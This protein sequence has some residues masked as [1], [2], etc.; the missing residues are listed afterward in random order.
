[1]VLIDT[2][3][4]PDAEKND[5]VKQNKALTHAKLFKSEIMLSL[6]MVCSTFWV[7]DLL[8]SLHYSNNLPHKKETFSPQRSMQKTRS[9]REWHFQENVHEEGFRFKQIKSP[10]GF[11]VDVNSKN[12]VPLL[13][14]QLSSNF[15]SSLTLEPF[16]RL[17]SC[18]NHALWHL[19][20]VP[21]QSELLSSTWNVYKKD[22][23]TGRVPKRVEI[24]LSWLGYSYFAIKLKC[25]WKPRPWHF[26][27]SP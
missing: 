10:K 26:R 21:T 14:W 12:P 4:L 6:K 13:H 27:L 22:F 3:F 19:I 11:F 17:V 9:Y 20:L 25:F 1:M 18:T 5:K 7:S 23:S 24:S 8:I 2:G 15:K 16:Q